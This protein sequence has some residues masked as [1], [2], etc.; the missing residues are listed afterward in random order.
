MLNPNFTLLSLSYVNLCYE[1]KVCKQNL[2]KLQNHPR[3]V[4]SKVTIRGVAT[5]FGGCGMQ[6]ILVGTI[7]ATNV[8]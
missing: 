6:R 1:Y 4:V 3:N 8:K 7:I 2:L 5:Q